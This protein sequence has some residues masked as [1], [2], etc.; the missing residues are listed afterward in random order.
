MGSKN[1]IA[2]YILPIMLKNRKQDQYWV[3][4]FVGGGN[5]I[6]KVDGL[7]IGADLNKWVIDALK[8]I[9]DSVNELPRNNTEF[10][11][12]DYKKLRLNDEYKHKGYA[13]FAFSYGSKWLGGWS[14]SKR[15]I[16]YVKEAYNSA[17]KQ[18]EKLFGVKLF[19]AKYDDLIIPDNSIIYCDPPY[20]NTTKYRDEFNHEL[21]WEWC[22]KKVN[23][24]HTVYIS[25]YNAPEDFVCVWQKEIINNL[26]KKT[27]NKK[28]IEKLFVHESQKSIDISDVELNELNNAV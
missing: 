15:N 11:E 13:G 28:G 2:K 24:G 3:E 17:A 8:S 12:Q 27:D 26:A 18:S 14:R 7:R 6:D 23:E 10:T 20:K 4:P 9:R 19:N 21:F 25:E 16:D 5:V 1:R 22:R